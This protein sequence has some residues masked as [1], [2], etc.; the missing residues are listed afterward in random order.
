MICNG[1]GRGS[2]LLRGFRGSR[3]AGFLCRC[4]V[5]LVLRC[6]FRWG[7]LAEFCATTL[8]VLTH[9]TEIEDRVGED[10]AGPSSATVEQLN[11]HS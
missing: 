11:L 6:R 1:F 3:L 2:H 8:A 9:L 5:G 10:D 7:E 4:D